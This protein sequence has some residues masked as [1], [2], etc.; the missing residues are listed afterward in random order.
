MVNNACDSQ[1]VA[2]TNSLTNFER[3]PIPLVIFIEFL[4]P[5]TIHLEV[6]KRVSVY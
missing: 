4:L 6:E 1:L 3:S 5:E 2:V